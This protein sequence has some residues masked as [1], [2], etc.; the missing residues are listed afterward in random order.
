MGHKIGTKP[1]PCSRPGNAVPPVLHAARGRSWAL[2]EPLRKA[3]TAAAR[4]CPGLLLV[5]GADRAVHAGDLR[6]GS[7]AGWLAFL[8]DAAGVVDPGHLDRLVGEVFVGRLARTLPVPII[9]DDQ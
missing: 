8:D 5:L 6:L 3:A 9:V 2:P 7:R 1:R 4:R